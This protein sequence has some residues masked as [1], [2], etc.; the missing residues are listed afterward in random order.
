MTRPSGLKKLEF[1]DWPEGDRAAW[2]I[3]LKWEGIL[4]NNGVLARRSMQDLRRYCH[5]FGTWLAFLVDRNQGQRPESGVEHFRE[6]E[7][8]SFLQLLESRLAPYSILSF[9]VS[10]RFAVNALQPTLSY[11]LLDRAISHYKRTARSRSD[12]EARMQNIRELRELG[13]RLMSE[14]QRGTPAMRHANQY[15]DGLAIIMLTAMP[16]RISNLGALDLEHGICRVGDRYSI[17][18]PRS[19]NG[20]AILFDLPIWLTQAIDVYLDQCRP[21]L[22][23]RRGRWWSATPN[24]AFWV[25]SNGTAMTARQLSKRIVDRTREAFGRPVNPHLFRDIVATTIATEDPEHVHMILPILSHRSLKTS[26][27]HYNH[28]KSLDASR[29]YQDVLQDFM[30]PVGG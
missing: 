8:R 15:R 18:V 3:A 16:L 28:A 29:R 26:E 23:A 19:K 14:P 11:P 30:R 2:Q 13:F 7:L 27:K 4:G 25:S 17:Y 12:K 6:E 21:Y 20:D 1:A 22:I 9:L 24:G 10:L 5:S